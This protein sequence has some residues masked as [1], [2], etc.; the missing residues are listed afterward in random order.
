M[1]SISRP[2]TYSVNTYA[3]VLK[4]NSSRVNGFQSCSGR[5]EGKRERAD[6]SRK[7]TVHCQAVDGEI[8]QTSLVV[9]TA[10]AVSGL[11]VYLGL[12]SDPAPCEACNG[13][14]GTKCEFCDAGKMSTPREISGMQRRNERALGFTPRDPYECDVC[15]GTGLII[16][17]VCKGSG[18]K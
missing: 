8:V 18:F 1:F 11:G 14:G 12:K 4:D 9:S 17:R 3:N 5:P 15:K 7:Q 2:C 10:I 13:N 16:C 6:T